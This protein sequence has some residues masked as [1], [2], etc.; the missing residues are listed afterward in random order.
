MRGQ[1]LTITRFAL[2]GKEA[3]ASVHGHASPDNVDLDW[4]MALT[5]LAAVQPSLQGKLAAQGHVGGSSQDLSLTADLTGEVATQGV[6]S[7]QFSAHLQAQ[8]LPS[9][10]AGN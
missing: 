8:G 9:R 10:P 6:N 5:D 1:D 2:N 4:S 7:G 3:T